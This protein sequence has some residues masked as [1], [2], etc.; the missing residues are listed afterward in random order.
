MASLAP[1]LAAQLQQAI[2][3]HEL[4]AV[5]SQITTNAA[6]CYAMV[7]E[8]VEDYATVGNTRFGGDPDLPTTMTWP[9]NGNPKSAKSRF[10][11]FIAQINFAELPALASDQSLPSS[12][13]LYL[14][15]RD[16][17]CAAKSVLIDCLFF[18]GDR[19]QLRRTPSP[20]ADRLADEYLVDLVPQKIRAVPTVS[21]AH[22]RK[23][24]RHDV[25]QLTEAIQ[26]KD[27]N[28]RLS[29]LEGDFVYDDQIGQMLGFANAGDIRQDLYR[30]VYLNRIGRG[31]FIND[32]W[33]DSIEQYES[34][35]E[36]YRNTQMWEYHSASR[37]GVVW[38]V[39]NKETMAQGVS[40]WRL[41]FRLDSNQAM[42]LNMM[43]ADPLYVFIRDEDL[44]ARR[45]SNL[46][47]EVTQG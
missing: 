42:D 6:E 4:G 33:W 28:W 37:E 38:L 45:F 24:F 39:N 13:I 7:I 3:A 8:D 26:K 1:A 43:D 14:F 25:E 31:E 2:E 12:G 36:P 40:E 47:G 20:D 10:S 15:V 29:E 32:D 44:A 17:V 35:L 30:R 23:K 21:I 34:F 5:T 18:D 41:L 11:N 9:C 16:M 46:A 22:Y 27:G 19:S